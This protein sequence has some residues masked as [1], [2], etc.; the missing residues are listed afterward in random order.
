MKNWLALLLPAML[1]LCPA[2]AK[3]AYHHLDEA[4]A[5]KFQQAYPDLVGTKLDDCA[6]CHTGGQY[7]KQPGQYVTVGSCQ[8]CHMTYGYDGSGDSYQTLNPYGKDYRA[9]GRSVS[10][11]AA[12]ESKDSDA[13]SYSNKQELEAVRYPGDSSDD[14]AKIAAPSIIYSSSEIESLEPHKQF[15][16]MNTTRGGTD[17]NDWYAEYE[18]PAI[19]QLLAEAGIRSSATSISVFSPDGWSQ[20]FDLY[21][22]GENYYVYGTYPDALFYYDASADQ[23]NGGWANYSAPGCQGRTNGQ[24]IVNPDGLRCILAYRRDGAYLEKGQLDEQNRLT[25][26]G[27]YRVVPPQKVPGPPDQT[28]SSPNQ[29]VI[30]PYDADEVE[31]GHNASNSPRTVTA[32]RVEP[33]PEG[34]TDFNWNEGGWTHADKGQFVV[35]G[36]L[37]SGAMSGSVSDAATGQPIE[38]AK[39]STGTGGY[40]CLTD[41]SGTYALSGVVCGA[42]SATYRL[43]ASAQGYATQ[44]RNVEV[45]DEETTVADFSLTP[46]TDNA[47]CPAA[48][49]AGQ[50]GRLLRPYRDFRDLVLARHS[51]GRQYIAAYYRYAPEVIMLMA[52]SDELRRK[53]RAALESLEPAVAAMAAGQPAE[54]SQI[55]AGL[56]HELISGLQASASPGLRRALHELQRDIG[57]GALGR[58]VP[59]SFGP[60]GH[61]EKTLD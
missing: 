61:N 15:L 55:Q 13:D 37:R 10:A 31:T 16:L 26:E 2:G 1:V 39:I 29:N 20:T 56:L 24:P 54:V 49:A 48:V 41:V 60:S 34:T 35:Y 11:F 25:G 3:A 45:N 4:D 18:G 23:A 42:G 17:G 59:V 36:A 52:R 47:T 51:R 57:S 50:N 6:L 30:W 7:E 28:A 19:E 43:S 21:A 53:M 58:S 32:I 46:A 5:P 33:L 8:W 27:P 9:A 44:S 38:K 14:P 12:I 40:S 22:G